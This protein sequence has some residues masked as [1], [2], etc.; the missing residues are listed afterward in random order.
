[1]LNDASADAEKVKN[2]NGRVRMAR[3]KMAGLG[4]TERAVGGLLL[5]LTVFLLVASGC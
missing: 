1:V 5:V 4:W 3:I 2:M